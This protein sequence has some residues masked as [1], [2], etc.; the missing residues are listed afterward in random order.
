M[1]FLLKF[2]CL[3]CSGKFFV[4]DIEDMPHLLE[5][6]TPGDALPTVCPLCKQ[7]IHAVLQKKIPMFTETQ[8]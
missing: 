4:V 1:V 2:A 5:D 6:I 7:R 3:E 8:N